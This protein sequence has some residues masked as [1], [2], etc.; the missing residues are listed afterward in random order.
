V[1]HMYAVPSEARRGQYILCNPKE[2]SPAMGILGLEPSERVRS[3][4][5]VWLAGFSYLFTF[6][7]LFPFM[8][9]LQ[10]PPTP[11]PLPVISMRVLLHTPIHPP[12][13]DPLLQHP[14]TLGHQTFTGPRASPLNDAR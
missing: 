13:P 1:H 3:G 12:T 9:P 8:V 14:P 6:Q 10:K 11:S 2:L 7:M 4:L 5:F